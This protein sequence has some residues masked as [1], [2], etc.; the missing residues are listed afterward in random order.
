LQPQVRVEGQPKMIVTSGERANVA[1]PAHWSPATKLAFRFA[2]VFFPLYNL[3]VP[4]HF[5]PIPFLVQANR[6][7]WN[8]LVSWT[9]ANVLHVPLIFSPLNSTTGSKDTT[10]NY[11]QLLCYLAVAALITLVWSVLDRK[12]PNYERLYEWFRLY[13]R[14]V[15]A[16]IMIPYGAAKLFPAQFPAPSLSTLLEPYGNSSPMRLLWTFMGASP[17]YSFFAGAVEVLGGALLI[18]PQLTTL[19]ALISAAAMTNVLMLNIGYDVPVKI[20]T[21]NLVLMSI[22]LVLPDLRRLADFF[23]FNHRVEPAVVRP[24]FRRKRL[25]QIALALQL[26]FGIVLLSQDLYHRERDARRMAE[27]RAET[28]LYG[29]WSVEEFTV[30]GQVRPPLLTDPLRWQRIIVESSDGLTVQPMGGL[31]EYF[32]LRIDPPGKSFSISKPNDWMWRADFGYDNPQ[33]DVLNLK[34]Q[35]DGHQIAATLRR[36]DESQFLLLNRGFH[37]INE[38]PVNH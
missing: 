22:V 23:V 27:I 36:V 9:A 6:A 11:V 19:G 20:F 5:I 32:G 34:G 31:Q 1:E 28:P 7:F 25:N 35:M 8:T 2:C 21:F 29:I 38:Y 12:R 24:L 17:S 10:A 15:L 18:V 3:W 33:P 26:L 30:D 4:L 14:M 16:A 37:W 13:L